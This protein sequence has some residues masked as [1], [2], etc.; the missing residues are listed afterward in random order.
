M[1]DLPKDW[2]EGTPGIVLH[3]CGACRHIF[4]FRRG[5]CPSCGAR[6]VTCFSAQGHGEVEACTEV[7]RAASIEQSAYAPY[8]ILLVK[9]IEGPRVM[10]R[11]DKDIVIGDPVTARFLPVGEGLLIPFF[12]HAEA[13]DE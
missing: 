4:Y 6:P 1:A 8:A 3:Q 5:F 10:A 7:K 11:G 13:A 2:T 12:V 9:L